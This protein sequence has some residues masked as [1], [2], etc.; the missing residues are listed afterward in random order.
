[1]IGNLGIWMNYIRK[2]QLNFIFN[3]L[4]VIIYLNDSTVTGYINLKKIIQHTQNLSGSKF[5]YRE[6][7]FI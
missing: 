2:I 3:F 4:F 7:L 5:V 6:Y 1:M